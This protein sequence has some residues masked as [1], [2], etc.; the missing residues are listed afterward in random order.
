MVVAVA[1]IE[2]GVASVPSKLNFESVVVVA[3]VGEDTSKP[4]ASVLWASVTMP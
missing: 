3:L 4:T 1:E 2:L